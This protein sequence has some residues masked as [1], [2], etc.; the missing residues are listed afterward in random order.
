M[1]MNMKKIL[2]EAAVFGVMLFVISNIVSYF[3]SPVLKSDKLPAIDVTLIDGTS[4]RS[5]ET[6]GKPLV[7][8]FWATWCPACKAEASNIESIS[9]EYGV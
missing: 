1:K 7:I 8:Y 6:E 5:K 3:R 4:F 2:R 9:K